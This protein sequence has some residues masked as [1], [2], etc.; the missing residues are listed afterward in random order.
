MPCNMTPEEI[1]ANN[2]KVA[3]DLED[4]RRVRAKRAERVIANAMA[5][6][7]PMHA[8]A[9]QPCDCQNNDP[10]ASPQPTQEQ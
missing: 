7:Y 10:A 3:K 8:K 5:G 2:A 4:L 9:Q 6:C 1:A